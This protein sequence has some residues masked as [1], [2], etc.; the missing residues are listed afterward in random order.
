MSQS[1]KL[2]LGGKEYTAI[3]HDNRTAKDVIH[4]MPLEL[5]LKRYSK[6]AP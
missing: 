6:I 4:M 5:T 2:T 1:I 3:F